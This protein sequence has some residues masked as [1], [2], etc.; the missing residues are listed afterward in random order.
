MSSFDENEKRNN[1]SPIAHPTVS[2]SV[3]ILWCTYLFRS[4]YLEDTLMKT[5]LAIGQEVLNL[6]YEDEEMLI[7]LT[8]DL[9]WVVIY[10]L[11]PNDLWSF[12]QSS[13]TIR[14]WH[15][16]SPLHVRLIWHDTIPHTWHV[17]R[18]NMLDRRRLIRAEVV[19]QQHAASGS[20]PSISSGRF[21]LFWKLNATVSDLETSVKRNL[22]PRPV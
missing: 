6:R 12:F 14:R 4:T 10:I 11:L 5:D 9:A 17:S 15:F 3:S 16:L 18:P 20:L 2:Y 19:V 1:I 21:I 22:Q 8:Q 7:R 13:P